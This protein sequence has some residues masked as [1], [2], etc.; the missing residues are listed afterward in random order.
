MSDCGIVLVAD[1]DRETRRLIEDLVA[2]LGLES[3]AVDSGEAALAAVDGVAPALAVVEVELPGLSGLAVL[4]SLHDRFGSGVPVILLS[5]ERAS[6]LDRAAGLM[7]GA[8]DYVVKPADPTE[9]VA[10]IRRS[11]RRSGSLQSSS[12]GARRAEPDP[13][14]SP[15]EQE[16]LALMAGGLSQP[17]IADQLVISS[18]TVATHIQRILAKLGVHSRTQALAEAFRLGLVSVM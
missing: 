9:L 14:L 12:A 15:R 6:P 17:E 4:E 8:D 5:A 18:R 16:I 11:L 1:R 2:R 13:G 10:R 7:L 3:L